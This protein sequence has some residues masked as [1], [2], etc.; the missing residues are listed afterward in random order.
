MRRPV[1]LLLTVA[2][3]A[4][5]PVLVACGGEDTQGGPSTIPDSAAPDQPV[6]LTGVAT[7]L[8]LDP[9][10]VGI[11]DDNNVTITPIA[12]ARRSAIGIRFPIVGGQ[13]RPDSLDGTIKHSGGFALSDGVRRLVLRRLIIDTRTGQV[14]ADAGTGRLPILNLDLAS[15][16][17]RDAGGTY[18][19]VDVP[20]KLSSGAAE[21]IDGAL[22]TSVLTPAIP[23]G[24]A[25]VT[26]SG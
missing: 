25:T 11:L 20:V 17:R 24:F 1:P 4:V 14:T 15:G 23:I 21:A 12:P 5:T 9:Q 19:L 8:D 18:R 16:K 6:A 3:L 22:S 26:A 7:N 10:T 2:L 13:V